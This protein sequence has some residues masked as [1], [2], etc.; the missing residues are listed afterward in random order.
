MSTSTQ[1]NGGSPPRP[2]RK[3]P[4]VFALASP[5]MNVA[6]SI[7]VNDVLELR[8]TWSRQQAAEFLSAHAETIG[9]AMVVRGAEVLAAILGS[10]GDVN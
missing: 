3:V 1:G 5:P 2:R 6:A 10:D 7:D 9:S 8:P 4:S